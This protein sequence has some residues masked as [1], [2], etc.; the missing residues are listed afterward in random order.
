MSPLCPHQ[1]CPY[2]ALCT[3]GVREWCQAGQCPSTRSH[4]STDSLHIIWF[5]QPSL[6]LGCDFPKFENLVWFQH[7]SGQL[8]IDK[9]RGTLQQ[10]THFKGLLLQLPDHITPSLLFSF[11]D[12]DSNKE[13][14]KKFN[15]SLNSSDPKPPCHVAAVC[16]LPQLLCAWCLPVLWRKAASVHSQIQSCVYQV[17]GQ[18]HFRPACQENP[19]GSQSALQKVLENRDIWECCDPG[20][21]PRCGTD[22]VGV[23]LWEMCLAGLCVCL[24]K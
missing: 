2:P 18:Q 6:C 9:T 7:N 22:S 24:W 1:H 4:S 8:L 16:F 15:R 17:G 3:R 11:P 23:H 14:I 21:S 5:S 13:K 19:P 10:K 12:S 20:T